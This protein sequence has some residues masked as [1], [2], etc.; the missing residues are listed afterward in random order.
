[1][2]AENRGDYADPLFY[3]IHQGGWKRKEKNSK[4]GRI[5]I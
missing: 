4:K 5:V 2:R 1:M 3:A